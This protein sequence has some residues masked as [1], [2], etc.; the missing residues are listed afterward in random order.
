MIKHYSNYC[1]RRSQGATAFLL[2]ANTIYFIAGS[3]MAAYFL[4]GKLEQEFS[5]EDPNKFNFTYTWNDYSSS[6]VNSSNERAYYVTEHVPKV[7]YYP[8]GS[9]RIERR[10]CMS[11]VYS[12]R[13]SSTRW[14]RI[15]LRPKSCKGVASGIAC[16]KRLSMF[17][18][19]C[20]TLLTVK[21]S[22]FSRA[23]Q[24]I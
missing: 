17:E 9:V 10:N 20:I 7:F 15:F 18:V 6:I 24:K 21:D 14:L 12:T 16:I 4:G 22:I 1:I 23:K 8:D 19:F 11:V 2:E 13:Q 5:S 3:E